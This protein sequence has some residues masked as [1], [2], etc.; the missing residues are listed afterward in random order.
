MA[1]LS[2]LARI[3]LCISLLSVIPGDFREMLHFLRDFRDFRPVI[4]AFTRAEIPRLAA[5]GIT[6]RDQRRRPFT[7]Y[8]PEYGWIDY[9]QCCGTRL[10]TAADGAQHSP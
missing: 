3:N 4:S 8:L 5:A 2:S 9:R 6:L 1:A 7:P 10:A